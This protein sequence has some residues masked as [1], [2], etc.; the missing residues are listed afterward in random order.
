MIMPS[1]TIQGGGRKWKPEENQIPNSLTWCRLLPA[2]H[3]SYLGIWQ[4][5]GSFAVVG[6]EKWSRLNLCLAFSSFYKDSKMVMWYPFA[7]MRLCIALDGLSTALTNCSEH[8]AWANCSA[9]EFRFD[10]NSHSLS[11]FWRL[12]ALCSF[13]FSEWHCA[14]LV[15]APWATTTSYY[16]EY[17]LTFFLQWNK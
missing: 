8:R 10:L 3:K 15:V 17:P 6:S 12:G 11:C 13:S 9:G 5:L 1:S 14:L 2:V 16:I 7:G 4:G